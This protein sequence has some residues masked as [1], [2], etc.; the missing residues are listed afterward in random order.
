[1]SEHAAGQ[2]H[3]FAHEAMGTI[4]EA[5]IA[6]PEPKYAAQAAQAI[7]REVDR[8]EALFSRFNASSEIGQINRLGPGQSMTIGLETHECLKMAALISAETGGA[9][10]INFRSPAKGT[11]VELFQHQNGFGLKIRELPAL[12]SGKIADLDL[13]AIGK[14][15]ALDKAQA[16]LADWGIEQALIHAGTST[17]VATGS[18]PGLS[19]GE[20]GWPVGVGGVFSLGSATKRVLLKERALSGSGTEVKGPHVKDPRTGRP[21]GQC[22]AAWASHPQAAVADALSTAFMVMNPDEVRAYCERHPEAWAMLILNQERHCIFNGD[23]F[24][25]RF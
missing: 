17:A 9:F 8:L 7:F 12:E 20:K 24:E 4:F 3:R 5:L 22:L 19:A 10:D 23:I 13:G 18:A 1:M 2:V 11:A 16:I 25:Q 21:A 6:E 15:F 14:G